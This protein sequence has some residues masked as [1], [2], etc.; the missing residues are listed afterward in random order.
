[1]VDCVK[2]RL[3]SLCA[4]DSGSDDDGNIIVIRRREEWRKKTLGMTDNIE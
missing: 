4:K 1:M 3:H 2:G